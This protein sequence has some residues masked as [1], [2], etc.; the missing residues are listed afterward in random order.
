MTTKTTKKAAPKKAAKKP[1]EKK[2]VEKVESAVPKAAVLTELETAE[3]K[4]IDVRAAIVVEGDKLAKLITLNGLADDLV[5]A[6]SDI[7][8]KVETEDG[9]EVSELDALIALVPE[10]LR[11]MFTGGDIVKKVA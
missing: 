2:P 3:A 8:K 6:G 9:E 5:S 11:P 7:V 10:R 4:L 1:V